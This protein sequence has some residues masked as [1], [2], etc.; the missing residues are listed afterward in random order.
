MLGRE[1]VW[2]LPTGEMWEGWFPNRREWRL[3]LNLF[4][5]QAVSSIHAVFQPREGSPVDT[6]GVRSF[7]LRFGSALWAERFKLSHFTDERWLDLAVR[8]MFK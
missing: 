1:L 5:C 3:S 2:S 4:S 7:R 6:A 8:Q